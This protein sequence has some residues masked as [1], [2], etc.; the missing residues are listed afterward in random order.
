M[1]KPKL[2]IFWFRRD[3]RLDDNIGLYNA[4]KGDHPVL[5]LFIFDSEILDKL[6]DKDDARVHFIHSEISDINDQLR[7]KN[8]GLLVKHGN[9]L[10]I[11]KSL[12]DQYDIQAIYANRDYEPYARSRDKEL[13]TLLDSKG[14]KFHS[15]KD[16]VIFEKNEVVKEDGDPYVVFTP[17]SKLWLKTLTSAHLESVTSALQ[18]E[19]FYEGDIPSIP[20]LNDIGFQESNIP[21]PDKTVK[22]SILANYG[23][24]RDYPDKNGTSRLGIHLRFGTISIRKLAQKAR[25]KS[26]TYLNELIWREF[27]QMIL[28]HF[29]KVVDNNFKSKYDRVHWRNDE[30]E[31]EAWCE[32]KTGYPIVDAGMRELNQTGHMHNRV[33]MIVAS[34]LTKHLLI[35]WKWGEAYFAR[36]LLDYELASNNGGWQ[37]AAG[38]GTDAQPYF[39]IFNPESQTK[40]FDPELKYIKK[41]VPEFQ[42]LSYPKP[43]VD[44]KFA[45]ERC[46]DTFKEALGK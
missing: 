27:Y 23:Q 3:L 17:Y 37:W 12:I 19:N 29:P 5:P 35:D 26:S 28:W 21:I 38:T 30:K 46:L 9:P 6:E 42:E 25:E 45:R 41:W 22:E 18:F 33:R 36:K 20:S 15:F 44:H 16:H 11:W 43:I 32:G 4:L 39:R 14:I 24:D 13:F 40:K 34:F 8:S 2:S 1:S 10:S 7:S 31:F